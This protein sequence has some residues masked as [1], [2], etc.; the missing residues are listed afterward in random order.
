MAKVCGCEK[1]EN[2]EKKNIGRVGEDKKMRTV[3]EISLT[4][5]STKILS[6]PHMSPLLSISFS[7][8]S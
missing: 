5:D 6:P 7:S 8:E 1:R 4:T 3:T 2:K